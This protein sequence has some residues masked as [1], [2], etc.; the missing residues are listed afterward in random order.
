MDSYTVYDNKTNTIIAQGEY[1]EIENY[2]D[3]ERYTVI[4]D[5][6]GYIL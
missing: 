1:A 3:D 6:T 2:V 4:W 5:F